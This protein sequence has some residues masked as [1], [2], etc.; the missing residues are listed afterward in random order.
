MQ[1]LQK[2]KNRPSFFN[3]KNQLLALPLLIT[4][5]LH[6]LL[7]KEPPL[8]THQHHLPPLLEKLH[9]PSHR[10]K[11]LPLILFAIESFPLNLLLVLLPSMLHRPS[12]LKSLASSLIK[13]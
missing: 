4:A 11:L 3:Q 10:N 9:L 13:D 6:Q 7:K 12:R 1:N 8:I 2:N 5:L